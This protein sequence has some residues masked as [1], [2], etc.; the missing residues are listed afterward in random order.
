MQESERTQG[1]QHVSHQVDDIS[2]RL[3][4]IE[5]YF[6]VAF[7]IGAVFGVG[8]VWG[9]QAITVATS[10][11]DAVKG[12]LATVE[13][14]IDR[15]EDRAD[16]V[17]SQLPTVE[18]KLTELRVDTETANMQV[19][20]ALARIAQHKVTSVA[21]LGE[22]AR[23]MN[24]EL[25]HRS[26]RL[27]RSLGSGESQ[28]LERVREQQSAALAA[29]EG[30]TDRAVQAARRQILLSLDKATQDAAWGACEWQEVG[31]DKSHFPETGAWCPA[32]KFVTQLDL[33]VR[34]KLKVFVEKVR[35]CSLEY[36][37]EV[38]A[39]APQTRTSEA[40]ADPA[41]EAAGR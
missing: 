20:V 40:S 24:E 21:D 3:A 16:Q 29:V 2:I 23:R 18:D 9:Y 15:V 33:G 35:C 22:T 31:V 39:K 30:E 38:P 10:S 37:H 19:E 36:R 1:D 4:K 32:G 13:S 7:A 34:K 27:F 6:K 17:L 12:D 8:G 5:T 28:A 25:D 41:Q 26:N 14:N 11:I